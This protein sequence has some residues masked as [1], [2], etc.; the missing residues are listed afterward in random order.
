MAQ[1]DVASFLNT[2][3]AAVAEIGLSVR[4]TI[5]AA[6]P[7]VR[8]TLDRSARVVGYGFGPGYKDTICTIIPSKKGVK[9]GI[10]RGAELPNLDGLLTGAGK[11]HRHVVVDTVADA[12]RPQVK[13]LLKTAYTAW[14][15]RS[16]RDA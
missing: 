7:G 9:L 1:S 3:P 12:K 14:K 15:M 11:I 10:V 2:Y 8:E 13:Q 6:I 5:R 4:D 16:T